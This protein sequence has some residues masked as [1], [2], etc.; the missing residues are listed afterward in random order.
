MAGMLAL[1]IVGAGL[2]KKFRVVIRD[3]WSEPTN[4]Y[5]A[6]ALLP[7]ER[8]SAVFA[9]AMGPVELYEREEAERM[10]PIIAEAASE[11]RMMEAR[12]KQSETKAAKATDA[13]ECEI[14]KDEAKKLAKDVAEHVV[15]EVPQC[16][17]D[18]VTPE[19]LANM[20][21]QQGGRM[22]L[23]SAEG[24]AFEIAKGRYSETANFDVFL[25]GHSGD[26][27]RVG[28]ISRASDF[29]EQPAL[30]CA[31]AVQPDVIR[32]LAEQASMRGRGFLARWFYAI[33]ISCVGFR[34]VAPPA[35]PEDVPLYFQQ[36]ML[37][38]WRLT[39]TV[40]AF[41]SPAPHRLRFSPEADQVLRE[42]ES[43]LEPQLADGE[44][45]SHLAGWAN[46][47]AGGIARLAGILHMA[48]CVAKGECEQVIDAPTVAAA[49]KL[50]RDYL[51]PHAQAAF[52][53]MGADPRIETARSVLAWMARQVECIEYVETDPPTFS[54]RDI[55]QGCRR[56]FGS[57]ED[58]DPVIDLLVKC[59]WLRQVGD[60]R[61]GRG[62]P[63]P[64]YLVNPAI[65]TFAEKEPPLSQRTHGPQPST[66][67]D[68]HGDAYE[69]PIDRG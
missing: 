1:G 45:L 25:K 23:A 6:V 40:D 15:P 48:Q 39:G 22:L 38:I 51:L 28:R 37:S 2:A 43:W 17:C 32:G 60:G 42:F 34:Q 44:E 18:D 49:V 68:D 58:V 9:D 13:I 20:L 67:G 31:L 65:R 24:T 61:P 19:K 54:R 30:S 47:L 56:R 59:C 14:L 10:Q 27:L 53:L 57:V 21:A 3:G 33:P 64:R 4:I 12:L 35:M 63:G 16:F 36:G 26:P 46:K 29:V 62:Q 8:K 7:G 69:G 52:G 55:H 5:V 50:G 66:N 11:H 41:G